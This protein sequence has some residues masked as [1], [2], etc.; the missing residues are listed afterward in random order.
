[1]AAVAVVQPPAG[2][3]RPELFFSQQPPLLLR[4]QRRRLLAPGVARP[5]LSVALDPAVDQEGVRLV[6]L[7]A[8]K[9]LGRGPDAQ[10]RERVREVA[11]LA[12]PLGVAEGVAVGERRRPQRHVGQLLPLLPVVVEDGQAAAVDFR[13]RLDLD[14]RAVKP[15]A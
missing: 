4:A 15:F 3:L 7:L 9:T 12:A 11:V 14:E 13:R 2:L 10:Q 1:L 6:L 5:A 8:P